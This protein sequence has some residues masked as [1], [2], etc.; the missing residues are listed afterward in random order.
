MAIDFQLFAMFLAQNRLAQQ[1]VHTMVNCCKQYKGG[2][3][4]EEATRWFCDFLKRDI[5]SSYKHNMY[6][7]IK[8]YLR[9]LGYSWDFKKPKIHRKVRMNISIEKCWI[10]V[11]SFADPTW[12]LL[13]KTAILTGL[14]PSELL[15]LKVSDIDFIDE[16]IMITETKTYKD[17]IIPLGKELSM[18]LRRY[19]HENKIT[20][21]IF[22]ISL[23]TY[24]NVLC[25]KSKELG[26]HVTPYMLRH[27]FATQ[28]IENGGNLLM[29]KNILG[30][31]NITTTEG[32]VHESKAMLRRDYERA[33][34]R[35]FQ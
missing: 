24:E 15:G 31:S 18:E 11:D 5:S 35:L 22:P 8:W 2:D 29:L 9:F 32:Y 33:K 10:L 3:T 20:G 27:T 6:F 14:R 12:K 26:F 21:K 17:R 19:I 13:L 30:H 1:T 23:R 28:Y 25:Q 16:T 34:P 7:A 4:P